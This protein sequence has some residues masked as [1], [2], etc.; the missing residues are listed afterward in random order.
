MEI[1][2]TDI[3]D[4]LIVSPDRYGDDRGFFSETFRD[5]WL[6]DLGLE[7]V[8]DN[9]S[10]SAAVGTV[11]GLHYQAEP[12]PQDKLVRVTRG[13]VLDVAVDIR[14][15]SPWYLQ[16][17]AVELS[18]DNWR[19][20]LVPKGF[21]HG[22]CTLAPDTEVLYKVTGYFSAE[23]DRAIRWDDPTLRIPWPVQ[24]DHAIVSAKDAGAPLLADLPTQFTYEGGVA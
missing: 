19:Q 15:G 7:F 16:H 13:A 8:Q 10:L 6:S 12:H 21:A 14:E 1:I 4:V 20:L 17:V 3:P 22:F 23:H 18:A 11:R 5:E 24:P 9:H 2:P